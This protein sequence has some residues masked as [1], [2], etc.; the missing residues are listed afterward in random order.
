[1]Q[2]DKEQRILVVMRKVLG[3]VV[4]DATPKPGDPHPLSQETLDDIRQCFALIVARER[5]LNTHASM[6]PQ[7]VD[8]KQSSKV[9]PLSSI[10]K[11]QD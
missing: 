3:S 5:E 9:V 7:Y 10:K 6:R 1:M 11:D 8:E 4:K 2:T